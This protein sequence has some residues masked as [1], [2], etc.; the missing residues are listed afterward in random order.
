M[1]MIT[2]FRRNDALQSD[3][4]VPESFLGSPLLRPRKDD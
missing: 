4:N 2:I 1:M 3:G